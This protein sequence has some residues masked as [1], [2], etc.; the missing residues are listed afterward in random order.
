MHGHVERYRRMKN[1]WPVSVRG[2][3]QSLSGEIVIQSINEAAGS[4]R[5]S[6]KGQFH[7]AI[8]LLTLLTSVCDRVGKNS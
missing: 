1:G 3:G 5:N 7:S 6:H 8:S 2:T 4:F